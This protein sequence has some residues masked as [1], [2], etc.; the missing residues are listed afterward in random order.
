VASYDAVQEESDWSFRVAPYAWVPAIDGSISIGPLTAPVDISFSDTLDKLDMAFMGVV[1]MG[2]KRWMLG[3]DWVYG[4]FSK[5]LPGR[6]PFGS[7]R[8]QY[9]QWLISPTLAYRAVQTDAYHMDVFVGARVTSLDATLTGRF[10]GGGQIQGGA[11]KAWV[12]PFIGVRGQAGLGE[13]FLLRYNGDIGGFGVSSDLVWS[14]FVGVGYDFNKSAS[15]AIGY[16][17]LGFDYASGATAFD[18][19]SHGPLI[20]FEIRF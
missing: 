16:R 2:Y 12:D 8:Y 4:N 3:A 7:F 18:L 5:D 19:V 13:N 1:E 10:A 17:G 9:S 14:A 15:V 20:G 11:E 6:G